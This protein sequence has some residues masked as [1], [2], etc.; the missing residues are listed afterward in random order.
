MEPLL[1]LLETERLLLRAM[2]AQVVQVSYFC[3]AIAFIQLTL[4]GSLAT[5]LDIFFKTPVDVVGI[6]LAI[7]TA[8]CMYGLTAYIWN[9][10]DKRQR[11][12]H[13][14]EA[15]VFVVHR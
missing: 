1:P 8:G 7:L 14:L 5:L 4:W 9:Q 11:S 6:V 3:V 12:V 13:D 15:C 10:C 2:R